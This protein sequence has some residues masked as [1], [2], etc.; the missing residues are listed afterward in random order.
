MRCCL[1][2]DQP[3]RPWS[4]IQVKLHTARRS[5]R[6]PVLTEPVFDVPVFTVPVFNG[7]GSAWQPSQKCARLKDASQA[8]RWE[9]SRSRHRLG[10]LNSEK[11]IINIYLYIALRAGRA[12]A[13]ERETNKQQF[14]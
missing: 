12:C 6:S 13:P 9:H 10:N 2:Y 3:L 7:P 14:N 4:L 11:V 5:S 1:S 8:S